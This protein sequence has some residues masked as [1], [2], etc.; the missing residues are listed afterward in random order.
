MPAVERRERHGLHPLHAV[1]AE[2]RHG[3]DPVDRPRDEIAR[4]RSLVEQDSHELAS[5]HDAPAGRIDDDGAV[6]GLHLDHAVVAPDECCVAC[7]RLER[8]RV[9]DDSVH[10]SGALQI[11][12]GDLGALEPVEVSAGSGLAPPEIEDVNS[13]AQTV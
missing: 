2:R 10:L 7:D 1:V 6:V 4:A 9:V 11:G 3:S 8:I 12:E 13:R 5:R